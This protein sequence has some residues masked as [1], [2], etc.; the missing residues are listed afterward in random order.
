MA[1]LQPI[2]KEITVLPNLN[3]WL[4]LT[5]GQAIKD[6]ADML[7]FASKTV[8]EGKVATISIRISVLSLKD[9]EIQGD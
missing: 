9:A 4:T 8:P 3:K 2:T 5:A 7:A 1:Y 6:N